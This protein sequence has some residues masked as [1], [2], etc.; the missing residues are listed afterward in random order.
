MKNQAT[1]VLEW[2]DSMKNVVP[3]WYKKA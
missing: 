1:Q 3:T 2:Y